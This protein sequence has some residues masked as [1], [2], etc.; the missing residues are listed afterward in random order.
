MMLKFELECVSVETEEAMRDFNNAVN[1]VD[2]SNVEIVTHLNADQ[3]RI[4]DKN[5]AS[6]ISDNGIL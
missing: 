1:K 3:K 4:L 2:D 5:T 6:I